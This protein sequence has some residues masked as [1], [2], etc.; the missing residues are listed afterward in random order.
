MEKFPHFIFKER[1]S[2]NIGLYITEKSSYKGAARDITYTSVPGRS[3]DLITDNGRYGNVT[4]P[5]K[6]ALLNTTDREFSELA[7]SIKG[8]L[9]SESGYFR[10]WDSY[11]NLYFRLASYSGEVDIEQELRELGSLDI[12]FNCKPFKYSFEG[13]KV[14]TFTAAGS[15]HNAEAFS[16]LPYMKITGSGNITLYI[17]NEAFVFTDVDEYIELDSEMMNACKGISPQN[18]KMSSS[19]FPKLT[20][21]ENNISFTGAVEKIE[22]VPRW[23][24]L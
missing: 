17:N 2:L 22:I 15:L 5:Y 6:L 9:S 21:G 8:W 11:D 23:C 20:P 3:G 4:I 14:I 7:R 18:N 19:G 12:S 10:L 13:E 16:S 24:S 1:S